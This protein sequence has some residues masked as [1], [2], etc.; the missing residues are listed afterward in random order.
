M[1]YGG[2]AKCDKNVENNESQQKSA[3]AA[4]TIKETNEKKEPR[5]YRLS[6]IQTLSVIDTMFEYPKTFHLPTFWQATTSRFETSIYT[7][8]ANLRV[9]RLGLR[10]VKE[11]SAVISEAAD[12]SA[13]IDEESGVTQI[14]V[15]IESIE[16]AANQFL[17]I[18][19]EL[20]VVSPPALRQRIEA[21]ID[22]M[23][24]IY[25]DQVS[26]SSP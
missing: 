19:A 23:Q 13:V 3:K 2:A 15:P 5:T 1:V 7:E 24:A 14:T 26:S 9:T 8:T 6:N 21:T 16:H 11:L 20:E 25:R 17:G 10:R 22:L 12:Q 18:G 4:K